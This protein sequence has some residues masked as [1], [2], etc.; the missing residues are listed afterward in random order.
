MKYHCLV[1]QAKILETLFFKYI[2]DVAA[3]RYDTSILCSGSSEA[4]RPKQEAL[5]AQVQNCPIAGLTGRTASQG[6]SPLVFSVG[7]VKWSSWSIMG[8]VIA[9]KWH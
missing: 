8:L 5:A 7:G 2:S 4:H 3:N 1:R 6:S 9:C